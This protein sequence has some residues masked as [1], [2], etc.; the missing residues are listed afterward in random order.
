MLKE[1]QAEKRKIFRLIDNEGEIINEKYFPEISDKELVKS[2]RDML[3]ARTADLMVVS[4]QRQGRIF[5]YPMNYGQEAIATASAAIATKDDWVVPAFRELA[6]W[7]A[8]GA[9][10]KD[11][12]LYYMGYEDGSKFSGAKNMFPIL[13]KISG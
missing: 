3:F 7:L 2:Y 12:F 13:H 5:T 8:K 1:Y 10:L 4:Y 9:S 11:I 6:L